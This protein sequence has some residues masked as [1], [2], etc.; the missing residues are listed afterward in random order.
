MTELCLRAFASKEGKP[1]IMPK[2]EEKVEEISEVKT[3]V[4]K[5]AK[6]DAKKDS[7]KDAKKDVKKIGKEDAGKGGNKEEIQK[8]PESEEESEEIIKL[9][10]RI[11]FPVEMIYDPNKLCYKILDHIP[12]PIFPDPNKEELPPPTIKKTTY[13]SQE[14]SPKKNHLNRNSQFSLRNRQKKGHLL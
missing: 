2:K 14:N 9:G 7:K 6:K 5:E 8:E 3:E 13:K 10:E 11:S 12:P 1:F 4:K